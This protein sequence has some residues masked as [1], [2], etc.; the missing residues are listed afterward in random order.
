MTVNMIELKNKKWPGKNLAPLIEFLDKQ[1]EGNFNLT[2]LAQKFGM[3]I[4]G[5]SQIFMRDS[6]SLEKAGQIATAYGYRLRLLFPV[7]N[8][9]P[10]ITA[11]L[12]KA[13][14]GPGDPG[15]LIGLWNYISDSNWTINYVSKRT[16]V[17]RN[18]LMLAMR[19]GNIKIA[20]LM[21]ICRSIG[22]EPIWEFTEIKGKSN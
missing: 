11:P 6:L 18:A 17:S 5:V 4:Q 22:I 20:T 16:G 14:T 19:T 2:L 1:M 15:E 3:S 8:Y 10:G 13:Y 21:N 12:R 7:R 9:L